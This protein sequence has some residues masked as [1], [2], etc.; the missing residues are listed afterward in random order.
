MVAQRYGCT[1]AHV[2]AMMCAVCCCCSC[3]LHRG[4]RQRR[5]RS[6]RVCLM[7]MPTWTMQRGQQTHAWDTQQMTKVHAVAGRAK[8]G[9][10]AALAGT[11]L[12]GISCT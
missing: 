1:K 6:S 12:R 7:K 11:W 8:V 2:Q 3:A 9:W 5:R 10:T 4:R